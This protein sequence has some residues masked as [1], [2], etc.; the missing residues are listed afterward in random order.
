MF[1]S[2]IP[3]ERGLAPRSHNA[4]S[5]V[6]LAVRNHS[7]RRLRPR[8]TDDHAVKEGANEGTRG[9]PRY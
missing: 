7:I 4:R 2:R 9:F 8:T 3:T 5:R 1:A 6:N